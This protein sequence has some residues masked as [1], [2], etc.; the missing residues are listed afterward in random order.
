MLFCALCSS[1]IELS[2]GPNPCLF[3]LQRSFTLILQAL[4]LANL[5]DPGSERVIEEAS[6]SGIIV[7]SAE[8][9]T[10]THRGP[11]AW[12]TYRVRVQCD[13]HYFNATCTKFCRPRDDKF[14]HYTCDHNGDKVCIAGWM[15]ANCEIAVCKAGCHPLHGKCDV[16]GDC[17][18]RPGWQG[19]F[20]DQCSPYPGCK[21]GYCNGSSWQCI[22]D[23]N[24]GGILCDQDL[25]YCG[26]HEPCL[27]GGTCENPAPDQYLCTCGEG[28]SG[29]NCEIVDNPCATQPCAHG[30][31][32]TA[33][34]YSEAA[35][36][37][38]GPG[39]GQLGP[40]ALALLR[41][42][43]GGYFTC[44]CAP[45]WA[46]DT[47]GINVDECASS[48]CLNG[49]TCVDLV[50]G[51]RCDCPPAW[52]GD[53]CQDDA[54]ECLL[55]P[56]VNGVACTNLVGSYQCDCQPG[57][58]GA[59][60]DQNIDDCV[61]QCQHGATC[62]DLVNDYHCA[63]RAGYTGR[64]CATDV[65]DCES[66]PCLRGGECVDLV[67]GFR[68]IC[69]V[70][71]AGTLCELEHD[72]CAPNPCRNG[73]AC[74][75]THTGYH[76]HC[77][78]HWHGKNCDHA[79]LVSDS[80][81]GGG[82]VCGEHGRCISTP[83]GSYKCVCAPGYTGRHCHESE[84]AQLHQP[85]R[86]A[87]CTASGCNTMCFS[88]ASDINDCKLNP[89]LNG[90]TCVDRVNSFQCI[91]KEGWE[92]DTC[93]INRND[94]EPNP[95]R[96]NG[97]CSD[98]VADFYCSC[99]DGWKGKTC[100]LRNSHCDRGTCRNGGDCRDL[101][102]TFACQCPPDWE[103]TVCQLPKHR[104]CD[105]KPCFNGGTC[106]N[107]G[108]GEG[109]TC[110]CREGF[111]GERC[112]RDV[113]DCSPPP[114]L[115]GGRCVDGV[116]WFRCECARG[117]TGPD[118]RI[119]INECASS[120]CAHGATCEDG[121]GQFRCLCPPGRKGLRCELVEEL[122]FGSG[123]CLWKGQY[124]AHNSSWPDGC[125]VCECNDS[126]VRCTRIWCGLDN[127]LAPPPHL[128]AQLQL[129]PTVA[130]ALNEVCVPAPREV[131]L[132]PGPG[133]CAPWGDC[134]AIEAGK[135]VGP[136]RLPAPPDCW[137]NQAVL[138]VGCS[139]L[140]LLLDHGRLAAGP[141]VSVEGLCRQLRR[142]LAHTYAAENGPHRQDALVLLC[143]LR[144]GSN[145]TIEVTV[146]MQ[147]PPHSD[148]NRAITEG[149][150]VL[151]ELI[152]RK[153]TNLSALIAVLEV[154]V[155]T[156][157][158][159]E[160]KSS[161]VYKILLFSIIA[162]IV[163][164]LCGWGTLQY[165]R[166]KQLNASSLSSLGA[167]GNLGGGDPCHS[168]NHHEDE[169]SNNLQNEENLRRYANP[170]KEEAL[171]IGGSLANLRMSC[172]GNLK[173]TA[174]SV[175]DLQNSRISVVR[176]LSASISSLC[177]ADTTSA[178]ML[179]M[180]TDKEHKRQLQPCNSGSASPSN[181]LQVC[182]SYNK[183]QSPDL[184]NNT[185]AAAFMQKDFSKQ[186]MSLSTSTT[187]TSSPSTQTQRTFDPVLTVVV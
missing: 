90:G 69:P 178:E 1:G 61:G 17:E 184:R 35:G 21:H 18:C 19:E 46:G 79:A 167:L 180:L 169:K 47:C 108:E 124:Q 129:P 33:H 16:P 14:G 176:P 131:C 168:R 143:E 89:C 51:F 93:A 170:I 59:N 10:L 98:R 75:S 96:N 163:F 23:T 127:C 3:L 5:S 132:G 183:S 9:Y 171:A 106:L 173:I 55:S 83:A 166:Q 128:Q 80:C 110:V 30:G 52:E 42:S 26:R 146:S 135:R 111:E 20:C 40:G 121:Y 103:G 164:S 142:L 6:Y 29:P 95:C 181:K 84:Y 157:L 81:G 53:Y 107:T 12:L 31:T 100:S 56:C 175:S 137:P 120:P 15:G 78:E 62:I 45:G 85:P 66:T 165:C 86:R 122:A 119:N 38:A 140:T 136:P 115:N 149:I 174:A 130:C 152:G 36:P 99:R 151:G 102:H 88:P 186:A 148:D 94:C 104:A 49:G 37:G 155:E 43:P 154:K 41:D 25:N 48:P 125:N 71:L 109:F 114:C 7:P 147:D 74:S 158:V 77:P 28:F 139:R 34:P 162:I 117:F 39:E 159:A 44:S 22:C 8:W 179:E 123:V 13:Q 70:G 54:D 67:N 97:T 156:A 161:A 133:P 118:C 91:C 76:C 73:A 57:W 144:S 150:R 63:C 138:G 182:L 101:G 153:H 27:N 58:E 32:C 134:R 172:Q 60:C 82:A 160:E 185:N 64:D 126:Q 11:V 105:S 72:H 141:A 4:D 50:A 177:G 112:Q 68:C 2:P 145:D 187:Q 24:W 65:N 113:D 92:G 116:N 87:K